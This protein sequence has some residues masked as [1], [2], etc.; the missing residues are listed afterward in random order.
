MD[1]GKLDNDNLVVGYLLLQWR[2]V[3]IGGVIT[4]ARL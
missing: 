4:F 2:L 3:C 1:F